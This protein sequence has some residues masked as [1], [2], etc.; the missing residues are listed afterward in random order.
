MPYGS[1]R[2]AIMRAAP[3]ALRGFRHAAGH[4]PQQVSCLMNYD[5]LE[6][7]YWETQT[8][9]IE[10]SRRK[11]AARA[12]APAGRV[13]P[14]DTDLAI[15]SGRRLQ[16]T[17]VFI[18]I[19][20]F[21][22]RPS[23]TQEEQEMILRILNFFFTEMIRLVEDYGGAVEKNTG[24]GLMAYFEDRAAADP[25]TNS[26]KRALA[27]ALTMD[28]T[29]E[30]LIAPVLRATGVPTL[31][32]RTTID[33]GPVTIARI[34]APRRFNANVAIGNTANFASRMLNLISAG[35]I[36]V[37]A[38]AYARVPQSWR[39][40]WCELAPVSTEWTYTGGSMPYPLYLYNGRWVRLI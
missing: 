5:G 7:S 6:R 13:I 22:S 31:Q 34:G 14:D 24:D 8:R 9:R 40:A 35:Q 11:I 29:N 27:C 16:A 36:A 21:S 38:N 10:Q 23:A 28:Y 39:T 3:E 12:D 32:F 2:S 33:Y 1:A 15:G 20:N 4:R 26:V 19:S 30:M 17:V 18:D 37:G 25:G